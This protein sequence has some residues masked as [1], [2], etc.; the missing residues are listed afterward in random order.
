[1]RYGDRLAPLPVRAAPRSVQV[2]TANPQ[3]NLFSCN[4]FRS[5]PRQKVLEFPQRP[6]A[7]EVQWCDL[8][9]KLLI[10]AHENSSVRK[11]YVSK[12]FREESGLL[13]IGLDEQSQESR[14]HDFERNSRKSRARTNVGEPT[15][16]HRH[17]DGGK[18]TL[19]EMTI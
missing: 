3:D 12:D 2:T 10:P 14:P 17:R 1:M 16:F 7:D 9:A 19:A 13:H 18:H 4:T 5:G 11:F 15:V 6:R 8:F